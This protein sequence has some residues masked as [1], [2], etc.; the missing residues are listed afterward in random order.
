M[1]IFLEVIRELVVKSL[2]AIKVR[3]EK[4]DI[5]EEIV[6][7]EF[8]FSEGDE[9]EEFSKLLQKSKAPVEKVDNKTVNTPLPSSS[10]IPTTQPNVEKKVD[11]NDLMTK[12]TQGL[13]SLETK[14]PENKEKSDPV[15]EDDFEMGHTDDE[16]VFSDDGLSIGSNDK[17][18]TF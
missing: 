5:S 11:G 7:E 9:D 10:I 14:K 8:S 4:D 16:I 13:Q 17:N 1:S 15:Y 6:E 3:I 18:D 2:E 12:I